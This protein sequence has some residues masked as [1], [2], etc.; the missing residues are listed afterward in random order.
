MATSRNVKFNLTAAYQS[1]VRG[2]NQVRNAARQMNAEIAQNRTIARGIE[3]TTRTISSAGAA[4]DKFTRQFSSSRGEISRASNNLV[5]FNRNL[6]QM[7]GISDVA[8]LNMKR[9]TG[10]FQHFS[11]AVSGFQAFRGQFQQQRI[12]TGRGRQTVFGGNEFTGFSHGASGGVIPQSPSVSGL[13]GFLRQQGIGKGGF[14]ALKSNFAL[15]GENLGVLEKEAVDVARSFGSVT[16]KSSKYMEVLDAFSAPNLVRSAQLEGAERGRWGLF[17]PKGRIPG[18][19][20]FSSSKEAMQFAGVSA[21]MRKS[22]EENAKAQEKLNRRQ[23]VSFG[24][25][26][27]L[28]VKFGIALQLIELPGKLYGAYSDV[29]NVETN[30]QHDV[31]KTSM[32]VKGIENIRP[33]FTE[34]LLKISSK[35]SFP[36]TYEENFAKH[37]RT[38]QAMSSAT[39][40][41]PLVAGKTIDGVYFNP[42][43]M[44]VLKGTEKASNIAA[45]GG[46]S[47]PEEAM[48][49]VTRISGP[50]Q[51]PVDSPRFTKIINAVLAT[52]DFGDVEIGEIAD[53]IGEVI[54]PLASV[55]GKSSPDIQDKAI[56][57]SLLAYGTMTTTLQPEAA[58]TGMRNILKTVKDPPVQV[59]KELLRL[60]EHNPDWDLTYG[61]LLDTTP[62]KFIEKISKVLG[63]QGE[64][65]D[66][67]I[68]SPKGK[69]AIE[70]EI[71]FRKTREAAEE[72]V[73]K[74]KSNEYVTFMFPNIRGLRGFDAAIVDSTERMKD[75]RK[76]MEDS[77]ASGKDLTEERLALARNTKAVQDAQISSKQ[78]M[79]RSG[80]TNIEEQTQIS[81]SI[82]RK[83]DVLEHKTG[84]DRVVS[85]ASIVLNPVN[86]PVIKDIAG[87]SP[88]RDVNTMYDLMTI[89]GIKPG[90]LHGYFAEKGLTAPPNL[91]PGISGFRQWFE[92]YD[93]G[94]GLVSD[95][96]KDAYFKRMAS[97]PGLT[98]DDYEKVFQATFGVNQNNNVS[99]NTMQGDINVSVAVQGE[100]FVETGQSIARAILSELSSIFDIESDNKEAAT[101]ILTRN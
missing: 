22:M 98:Q 64:L 5:G 8:F 3:Q 86:L 15:F 43:V 70:A 1:A 63:P 88:S 77:T 74:T 17:G 45:A 14:N 28:M 84:W 97:D 82:N 68:D 37:T 90:D 67:F 57:G 23:G 55:Y 94:K 29:V 76:V 31:A 51:I 12:P 19:E 44:T 56:I 62:D 16:L 13:Q 40:N 53:F 61:A 93:E 2:F 49:I 66:L 36:G 4:S 91:G 39:E 69:A 27:G 21:T 85:A 100:T 59:K 87:Y 71:P 35:S 34:E 50:F 18:V 26:L 6:S 32:L 41:I 89:G 95:K 30:V 54:S 65:T 9:I 10:E 58:T 20:S 92:V 99:G 52:T 24:Q 7:A 79:V 46:G 101:R 73:R 25:L 11:S 78:F 38:A 75:F 72:H 60:K 42:E 80:I 81:A 96:R 83:W 48:K 33:E 47:S